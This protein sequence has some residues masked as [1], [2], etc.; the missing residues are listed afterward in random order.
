MGLPWLGGTNS[1]A[2]LGNAGRTDVA[3]QPTTSEWLVQ[4]IHDAE[5]LVLSSDDASGLLRRS[6]RRPG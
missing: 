6:T 4:A 5:S 2:D 3:S 1:E